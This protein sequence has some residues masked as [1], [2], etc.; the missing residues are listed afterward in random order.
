MKKHFLRFLFFSRLL[1]Q[2]IFLCI[3]LILVFAINR[4]FAQIVPDTAQVEHVTGGI[5]F[6]EGPLWHPDGF[7]LCSDMD[8]NRIFK[9]D[10]NTGVKEDYLNL[11]IHVRDNGIGM[12]GK[13]V[14]SLFETNR[15]LS[16]R[17]TNNEKGTGLGLKLCKEH[18]EKFD[19]ALDVESRPGKGSTFSV[20]LKNAIPVVST[21]L[22]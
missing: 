13:V 9:I 7:L 14:S 18:L 17:G 3:G 16:T 1:I 19:C 15:H 22:N 4:A 8:G 20:K 21:I 2:Y 11:H 6:A 12:S 5:D 10:P